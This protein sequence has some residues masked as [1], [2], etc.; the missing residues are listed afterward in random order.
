VE[1][2]YDTFEISGEKY[3]LPLVSEVRSREGKMLSWNEVSYHSYHKYSAD[4]SISF[5]TPEAVPPA[6]KK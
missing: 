2:N 4:A 1:L 5:D 3:V 6:K